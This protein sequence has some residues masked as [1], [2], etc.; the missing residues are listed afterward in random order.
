MR[1]SLN[2]IRETERYLG[3]ELPPEDKLVFEARLL[4]EPTLR[5]NTFVQYRIRA[6]IRLYHRKK[7]KDSIESIHQRMFND[8]AEK[9]FA[10]QVHQYFKPT[11]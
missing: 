10:L 7:M 5:A 11:T 1:T 6:L 4:T 8:P 3:N 9:T 2:D